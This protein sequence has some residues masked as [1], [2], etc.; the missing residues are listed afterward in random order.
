MFD[1]ILTGPVCK[2]LPVGNEGKC[3]YID[4]II[5]YIA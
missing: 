1:P 3:T 2:S 5:E 4:P